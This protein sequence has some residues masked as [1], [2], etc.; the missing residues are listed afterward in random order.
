EPVPGRRLGAVDAGSPFGDVE[1]DLHD[2]ALAPQGLDQDG[3]AGL[4]SLA[5]PVA[6]GPQED[7]LGGL[8]ADGRT[9]AQAAA[10]FIGPQSLFDR[11]QVKA[12][13]AAEAGVL[14]GDH[15]L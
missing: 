12:A 4:E 14:G 7:V 15:R 10:F 9:A 13:V 5:D 1:I 3:V 6:A 8:L 11:L 2:P